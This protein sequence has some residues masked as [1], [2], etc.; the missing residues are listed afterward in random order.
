MDK[1]TLVTKDHE[2]LA[3][4][5]HALHAAGI[6]VA[7]VDWNY[8]SEIEEW[9]L[10]IGTPLYDSKGP[11][12]AASRVIEALEKAGIYKEVP[13]L[14]VSVSSPHDSVVKALEREVKNRTEGHLHILAHPRN[15]PGREKEYSI[16][17]APF[18]GPGGAVPAKHVTDIV[19]LR[20]FLED[21]LHIGRSSVEEALHELARKGDTTIL[22][23]QLTHRQAK[24]L[25][26]A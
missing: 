4:V 12:E 17:F 19:A 18:S 16:I 15:G 20:Q 11:R 9:Q 1:A 26:L 13:I 21:R 25:G 22:N 23:V 2:I 14:K 6:G 10:V 8:D 24:K 7:V 3:R 5:Q